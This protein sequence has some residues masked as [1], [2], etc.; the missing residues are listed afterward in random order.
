MNSFVLKGKTVLITGEKTVELRLSE[1]L[2]KSGFR[3]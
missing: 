3:I 1:R 2:C